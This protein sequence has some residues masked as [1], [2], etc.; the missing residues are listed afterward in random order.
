M[1]HQRRNIFFSIRAPNFKKP[2]NQ[3]STNIY[4]SRRTSTS[5]QPS[6][7][8]SPSQSLLRNPLQWYARKLD[9]HPLTT[10]CLSSGIIAGSGDVLCQY[11]SRRK[12]VA[13]PTTNPS[14]QTTLPETD[15][16]QYDLIRSLR[17]FVLGSCLV[18]PT[19]HVWYG[20]LMTR[21]PG[22]NLAAVAKRLFFDQG[23]FA[24]F[25]LPT[26]V[27]CLTVLE[28]ISPNDDN[29]EGYVTIEEKHAYH[30]DLAS[31]LKLRMMNDVP[32]ATVVG[33]TI[34][35]PSMAFMFSFVPSKFQVLFSNGVGFVWNAYLSWRT[36][37][38]EESK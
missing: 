25:F 17:F 16:Q 12:K 5:T 1:F 38:G 19:V 31:H 7:S 14:T 2:S 28:H 18:A 32:E 20:F 27:S 26:F 35:V 29:N 3:V 15:T 37:E 9:T 36:H 30:G 6:T 22:N 10:K 23:L 13:T 8:T 34:W 21:I 4:F 33:W 11:L 24:P